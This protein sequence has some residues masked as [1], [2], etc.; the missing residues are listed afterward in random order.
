[1]VITGYGS[2]HLKHNCFL[3]HE[4]EREATTDHLDHPIYNAGTFIQNNENYNRWVAVTYEGWEGTRLIAPVMT[5]RSF[6]DKFQH[7]F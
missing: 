4:A 2:M 3:I 7:L 6:Y 5:T 1:M